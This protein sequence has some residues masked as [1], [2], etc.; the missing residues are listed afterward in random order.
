MLFLPTTNTSLHKV[1]YVFTKDRNTTNG[2]ILPQFNSDFYG[3]KL[4]I[5]P[6][7]TVKVVNT[8]GYCGN[9]DHTVI[10]CQETDYI[11]TVNTKEKRFRKRYLPNKNKYVMKDSIKDSFNRVKRF[12]SNSINNVNRQHTSAELHQRTANNKQPPNYRQNPNNFQQ[13]QRTY[14]RPSTSQDKQ[15]TTDHLNAPS[16]ST[17]S[18]TSKG[19]NIERNVDNQ[20]ELLKLENDKLRKINQ[21]ISS[22]LTTLIATQKKQ[23]EDITTLQQQHSLN[24]KNIDLLR[25]EHIET[26]NTI[27]QL[28]ETTST[29]PKMYEILLQL[30]HNS[31]PPQQEAYI[32]QDIAPPPQH[33]YHPEH[34]LYESD[35]NY[36]NE[37]E[38][39]EGSQ[40]GY[41]STETVYRTQA[42]DVNYTPTPN[43]ISSFPSISSSLGNLF[44]RNNND[45]YNRKV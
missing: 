17:S 43:P 42:P 28:V 16:S 10:N 15:Q 14:F 45:N 32:P 2:E 20:I 19:K 39:Q 31:S 22:Q 11:I 5:Y 1:A 4:F 33:S 30:Q 41:E 38:E 7:T 27:Q 29:I 26:T 13:S 21:D 12:T 44:G 36:D 24:Q 18:T 3:F 37:Y 35:D 8:C 9:K 23:S 40:S 6:S 25:R 34:E